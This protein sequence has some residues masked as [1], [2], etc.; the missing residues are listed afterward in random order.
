MMRKWISTTRCRHSLAALVALVLV[1]ACE[2]ESLPSPEQLVLSQNDLPGEWTVSPEGPHVPLGD[3]PLA[4]GLGA[5]DTSIVFYY[6]PV[7]GGSAGAHEQIFLFRTESE[8]AES[9]KKLVQTAFRDGANW[10]WAPPGFDV[11][12]PRNAH[13]SRLSCTEG[14]VEEMCRLIAR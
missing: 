11:S 7:D 4:S 8:A 13:E 5:V 3:A 10:H 1:A 6:H 9:Y 14:R 12:T 2:R